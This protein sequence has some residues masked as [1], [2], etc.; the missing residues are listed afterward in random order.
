MKRHYDIL[1]IGGGP[2][3][4]TFVREIARMRDDIKIMLVDAKPKTGS[5]VC[6]GLLAPDAQKVLAQ[7]DLSLPKSVLADPQI[8]DVRTLDLFSDIGRNYQRHYLNMDRGAFDEWLISLISNSADVVFGR[9][10]EICACNDGGFCVTVECDGEKE[11]ILADRIVGADGACSMVRKQFFTPPKKQYVAIQ[12]HFLD[13]G[14]NVANYSCVFD[15]VTSPSCSWTIRKNGYVIF[16][17]AFEKKDCRQAYETQKQRFEKSLG[18]SLGDA[19]KREACLVTS[20]RSYKD[21][22][23]GK[24]GCFLIGEAAGFIS[25]SSF[26][27]ISSAFL[28][29]KYLADSFKENA[30]FEKVLKT[31]KRKTLKLRLKLFLKTFKRAILFSPFLR[32]MIMKSG[33][34]SIDKY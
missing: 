18:H 5:K 1:V 15:P 16:G 24:N 4:A 12:E 21:F 9:C 23:L 30:T 33:L 26:E 17:G 8:F 20:V 25:S 7:F 29:G 14:T 32:K 3:G 31:Y 28:S 27:G 10:T 11:Q 34:C 22:A 19:V 13:I 2:A 6:G